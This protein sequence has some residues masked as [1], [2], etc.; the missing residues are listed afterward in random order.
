MM[1]DL[2]DETLLAVHSQCSNP[3]IFKHALT[4]VKD[5]LLEDRMF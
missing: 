4:E 3:L 2:A 1:V 5:K